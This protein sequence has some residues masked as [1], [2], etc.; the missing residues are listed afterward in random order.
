MVEAEKNLQVATD[1]I[2]TAFRMK[3]LPLMHDRSWFM[4]LL[5]LRF[6]RWFNA[7]HKIFG[8]LWAERCTSVIVEGGGEALLAMCAYLNLNDPSF[9]RLCDMA[10]GFCYRFRGS[11]VR[12]G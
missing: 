6:A 2:W 12:A 10:S 9:L 8:T 5:K 1:E 7:F 4:R 3:C 11:A